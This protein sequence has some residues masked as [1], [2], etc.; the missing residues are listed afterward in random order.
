MIEK[1]ETHDFVTGY[2]FK[3]SVEKVGF[4]TQNALWGFLSSPT[5]EEFGNSFPW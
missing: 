3:P 1:K 4:A 2:N 5:S